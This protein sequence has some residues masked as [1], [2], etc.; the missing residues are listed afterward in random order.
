MG[1]NGALQI[2][3]VE[4]R[5]LKPKVAGGT[6]D[7][8]VTL[9]L[10]K[11]KA[12]TDAAKG[13]LAPK[14]LKDFKLSVAAE[15]SSLIVSV[16]DDDKY[17]SNESPI[18]TAVI[19]LSEIVSA[20]TMVHWYRLKDASGSDAGEICLVL[21]YIKPKESAVNGSATSSPVKVIDPPPKIVDHVR[22]LSEHSRSMSDHVRA[23][24]HTRTLSNGSPSVAGMLVPDPKPLPN[25]IL[26]QAADAKPTPI[27]APVT[28]PSPTKVMSPAM[29]KTVTAAAAVTPAPSSVKASPLKAAVKENVVTVSAAKVPDAKKPGQNNALFAL[30]GAILA[31]VFASMALG[32]R[33]SQKPRALEVTEARTSG[34]KDVMT[35]YHQVERGD[36]LCS[37]AGCYGVNLDDVV[38]HNVDL[39]EDPDR[40]YPGDRIYIPY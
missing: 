35:R 22:S 3:V 2:S 8:Y 17:F 23:F 4:G 18:G 7:P 24:D 40:I 11:E 5:N 20:G 19:A 27:F 37:I 31:V 10:G 33:R 21:R 15:T 14:W 16:V 26:Q 1:S 28:Q 29:K 39:T 25:T 12:R 32:S 34:Y 30:G 38:E 9:E 36:T 13:T 6:A